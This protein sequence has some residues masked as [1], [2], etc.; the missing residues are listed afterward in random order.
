MIKI[1]KKIMEMNKVFLF[2]TTFI[3]VVVIMFFGYAFYMRNDTAKRYIH[4]I[5]CID[6]EKYDEAISILSSMKDYKDSTRLI[7]EAQ[8]GRDYQSAEKLI[9]EKKYEE[10][11]KLLEELGDYND[12][13]HLCDKAKY[14]YAKELFAD[15]QYSKAKDMFEEL[16]EYE[17][18]EVYFAKC[19]I[20]SIDNSKKLIYN[21]ACSLQKAGKYEEALKDFLS[22]GDYMD[23]SQKVEE[24]SRLLHSKTIAA[25]VTYSLGV[26][27]KG[28][29]VTA[30]DNLN[31]RCDVSSWENIVSIDGFGSLT[32]GL[33]EN[34]EVEYAG[35]IGENVTLDTSKWKHIIDIAAGERYIVGL[36]SDG[37]VLAQGHNGD[38]Q[39]NVKKWKNVVDIATG[40][41]FTVGLTKKGKLLFAG[42]DNGQKEQ[43]LENKNK[44]KDVIAVEC[45][46]AGKGSKCKGAGH[47]VGLKKDGTVVAIGDNKY[48]QCEVSK[49][50][51]IVSIAAGD[52]YTVGLKSDG[53]VLIT[54]SNEPGNAYIDEEIHEWKNIVDIAAGFG[55]TLGLAKNGDV[56]AIGYNTNNERDG[57]L[58]WPKIKKR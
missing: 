42:Y 51:D 41:R 27:E 19:D 20:E 16:G 13:K 17:D 12:A 7:D 14:V 8:K 58:L 2:I 33:K 39:I 34:G 32:I 18:S 54:G 15:K 21:E 31:G 9:Q 4:S 52:W 11:I 10:A 55:Q 28:R 29:V 26:T 6:N 50:R 43:Y 22:L 5:E 47:T 36:E 24:I 49:W 48:G 25:G 40:W 38:G 56:V 1:V 3:I 35:D 57:V 53:T 23:S 37:T 30:G 45:G 44:W 46:G